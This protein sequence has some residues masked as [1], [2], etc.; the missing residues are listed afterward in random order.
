[1]PKITDVK[2]AYLYNLFKKYK[3]YFKIILT[4]YLHTFI[5]DCMK[6]VE[7][8]GLYLFEN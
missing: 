4:V 6:A 7:Y 1:M 8:D 5:I 3:F 2:T